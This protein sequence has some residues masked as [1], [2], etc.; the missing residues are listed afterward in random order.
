[1]PTTPR[2]ESNSALPQNTVYTS[3]SGTYATPSGTRWLRVRLVGGGGG[4]Q[5]SGSSP[6]NGGT[7]G[8]IGGGTDPRAGSAG[9]AGLVMVEAHF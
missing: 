5:G 8:T 3:G 7:V 2:G 9:A 6:G 4:G 1:M